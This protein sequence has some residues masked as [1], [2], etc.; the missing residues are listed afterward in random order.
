MK[1]IIVFIM[2]MIMIPVLSSCSIDFD[3][4]ADDIQN[5]TIFLSKEEKFEKAFNRLS[6]T[7]YTMEGAMRT[8]ITLITL[9]STQKQTVIT[10]MLIESGTNEM[11][12]ESTT[13]GETARVYA[14]I[15][16]KDVDIYNISTGYWT[17][18]VQSLEEYRKGNETFY[19]DIEVNDIFVL[20]DGVWVGNT[21]FITESLKSYSSQF[22]KELGYLDMSVSKFEIEKYNVKMKDGEI[23]ELDIVIYISMSRYGRRIDM[24]MS[25]PMKVSKVGKTEVTIPEGINI[26]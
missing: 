4:F 18:N 12:A 17:H 8:D 7:S 21:E 14:K 2:L 10:D 22:A 1:K 25:L 13:N 23:S 19:L 15:N 5:G 3:E 16:E 6:E 11:Y 24:K 20:E 9:G 26:S